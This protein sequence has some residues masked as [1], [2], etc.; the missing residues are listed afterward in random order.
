MK[1]YI[2]AVTSSFFGALHKS[3]ENCCTSTNSSTIP[4][5]SILRIIS[6][7]GFDLNVL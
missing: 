6:A 1:T 5:F 7:K 3:I 2:D 4:C